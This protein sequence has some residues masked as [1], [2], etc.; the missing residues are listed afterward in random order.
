MNIL[1][2]LTI[3]QNQRNII[4][5]AGLVEFPVVLK[6]FRAQFTGFSEE[7]IALLQ[8]FLT[9]KERK[10]FVAHLLNVL[11][12]FPESL[13]LPMLTAAV[14][15]PN[16]SFN[17]VFIRPCR[18]VF[19][20]L[21]VHEVLMLLFR[22][23]DSDQKA[24]VIRVLYWAK[25]TVFR[26]TVLAGYQQYQEKE[27]SI[28]TWDDEEMRYLETEEDATD[29]Y[30]KEGVL[31]E[32]ALQHEKRYLLDAFFDTDNRE[33]RRLIIQRL[34][35]TVEGYPAE[36]QQQAA[37]L[38]AGV[39]TDNQVVAY[40]PLRVF[41]TTTGAKSRQIVL[42]LLSGI[43]CLTVLCFCVF[44]FSMENLLTWL[45]ICGGL[46]VLNYIVK[47]HYDVS[48]YDEGLIV[49]ENVW[50]VKRRSTKN[51]KDI[52]LWPLYLAFINPFIQIDF[53]DEESMV[54]KIPHALKVYFT[55]GGIHGYLKKL[56]AD[57]Q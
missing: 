11:E 55:K 16:A 48:I 43:L 50:G 20:Y 35:M 44:Y 14:N 33:L 51:I 29:I 38:L 37:L 30:D 21:K 42:L 3:Y 28:F 31:Q 9:D 5:D 6:H 49:G 45:F 34:P 13:L 36:L 4:R 27:Q 52:E 8:T 25:P 18:R 57:L 7:D 12:V 1:Q 53:E 24:G 17:N 32:A 19:G 40:A 46:L 23:G 15:E 10:W 22:N 56:K 54:I 47:N 41:M 26:V 2:T 39:V